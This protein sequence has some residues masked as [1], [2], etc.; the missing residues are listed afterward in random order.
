MSDYELGED[1]KIS[2]TGEDA[3]SSLSADEE[4]ATWWVL[5]YGL[6]NGS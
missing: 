1:W 6:G 2:E 3:Q 5:D 4:E